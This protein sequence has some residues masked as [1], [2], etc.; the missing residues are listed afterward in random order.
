MDSISKKIALIFA[1]A[2]LLNSAVIADEKL[3]VVASFSILGDMVAQVGGDFVDVTVLVGANED[4]HVYRPTPRV[5]RDIQKADLVVLNGLGFEGWFSRLVDSSGYEGPVAIA[6]TG[7]ETLNGHHDHGDHDDHESHDDHADHEEHAHD[8]HHDDHESHDDHA[9]HEEHAYDDHHDDHESHDDHADHEEHANHEVHDDHDEHE[10]HE[11][12]EGI[13]PHAWHSLHNAQIYISNIEHALSELAPEQADYFHQR[14]NAYNERLEELDGWV[15]T[16]LA[17]VETA[18]R[19]V[20]TSHNAFQYITEDY[21]IH[22]L[23]AQ[24]V[25]TEA[26]PSAKEVAQLIRQIKQEGVKAIF[27]ENI[28]DSRLIEQ[29]ARETGVSVLGELY[30]DALSERDG[31]APTYLDMMQYNL[32][33]LVKALTQ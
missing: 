29:V 17:S 22:F 28:S 14:A 24:G 27:V 25:S 20:I 11:D 23:S 2:V 6:A 10:A 18:D 33:S 26:E 21:G 9:D 13:N 15:R 32:T 30:S 12:E 4:A 7:I 1:S 16:E 19:R 3:N 31:K 5:A 8:E